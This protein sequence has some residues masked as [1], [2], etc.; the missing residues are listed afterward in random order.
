[1]HPTL[2]TNLL[3]SKKKKEKE[4]EIS[5]TRPLVHSQ[6]LDSLPSSISSSSS[7]FAS[8]SSETRFPF[9]S[10]FSPVKNSNST[11]SL[12]SRLSSDQE[13]F[14][15]NFSCA[16]H[17]EILLPGK[18]YVSKEF[19]LFKQSVFNRKRINIPVSQILNVKK[20]S[21]AMVF[22]NAIEIVTQ[23][24]K[25]FFGSF[26]FREKAYQL[27]T[28]CVSQLKLEKEQE[29]DLVE[30]SSVTED[31]LNLSHTY[32]SL[33]TSYVPNPNSLPTTSST[34]PRAHSKKN[35]CPLNTYPFESRSNSKLTSI[36]TD[37]VR[38]TVSKQETDGTHVPSSTEIINEAST[39]KTHPRSTN[40]TPLTPLSFKS[41]N[42]MAPSVAASEQGQVSSSTISTPSLP[43]TSSS[44][45][46]SS[47]DHGTI[48]SVHE[49]SSFSNSSPTPFSTTSAS[50]FPVKR[51]RKH[52][53]HHVFETYWP[54]GLDEAQWLLFQVPL[55]SGSNPLFSK[56]WGKAMEL[57]IF[58]LP[59]HMKYVGWEASP[60]EQG[61]RTVT[62]QVKTP[63][64]PQPLMIQMTTTC[65]SKRLKKVVYE[66]TLR[67]LNLTQPGS[68]QCCTVSIL[69]SMSNPHLP[70][71]FS[72]RPS[73]VHLC[74]S[75]AFGSDPHMVHQKPTFHSPTSTSRF[76]SLETWMYRYLKSDWARLSKLLIRH[77][78][79]TGVSS[80]SSPSSPS[81][82]TMNSTSSFSS[83]TTTTTH[84]HQTRI[85]QLTS[86]SS[87][88]FL[89]WWCLLLFLL[90]LIGISWLVFRLHHFTQQLKLYY[91]SPTYLQH[92]VVQSLEHV[93]KLL[94][95]FETAFITKKK[96]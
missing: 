34:F 38:S 25:Y 26:L 6:S 75:A 77:L 8:F 29:E 90:I 71:H 92:S 89:P 86:T 57:P 78:A 3:K 94:K 39:T 17:K 10:S 62:Y 9:T 46:S 74:V 47:S 87:S 83:S 72:H 53:P 85:H 4:N 45:S 20:K 68:S 76:R 19:L 69:V 32:S 1:S 16:L 40:L 58:D 73:F 21:T 59:F 70:S 65:V 56:W 28:Q 96:E 93:Q 81:S 50:D 49:T 80:S 84:G 88:N 41:G 44:S 60:W 48:T 54:M 42:H 14:L 2:S 64:F 63:S 15:G 27:I 79:T 33:G 61:T 22:P 66:S 7:S 67:L 55:P 36:Q 95:P 30:S 18:L 82:T 11:T 13:D 91:I 43:R 31:S 52:H 51:L 24:K 5:P 37:Q 23:E 12:H 35:H